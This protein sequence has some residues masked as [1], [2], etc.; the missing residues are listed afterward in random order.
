VTALEIT[1]LEG[2]DLEGTIPCQMLKPN[3]LPCGKPATSR[4][5][6]R[7]ACGNAGFVF[8]CARCTADLLAGSYICACC[9]LA[10]AVVREC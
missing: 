6:V 7:C 10:Q 4:I 1:P 9:D 8:T 3:P 2:I 5:H